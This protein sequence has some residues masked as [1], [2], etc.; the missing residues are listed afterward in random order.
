MPTKL[1]LK[2]GPLKELYFPPKNAMVLVDVPPLN[3]LMIDG[4]GDPNT[5]QVFQDAMGALYG[6]AYTLKF[7]SKDQGQDFTVMPLEGLWWSKDMTDFSM[8]RKDNWQW[9][10]LIAQPEHITETMVAAAAEQVRAKKNPP[11]LDNL[12]FEMYHEGLAAQLLYIGPYADEGPTITRLHAWIAEQGYTVQGAKPH[13]EIYM[14]APGRTQP[15][16][17]KTVIRQPVIR[18]E[19]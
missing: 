1:D 11:G 4:A 13:H 14:S 5:A 17:L 3:F 9:T 10:V 15:E 2:K 7:M 18:V 8:G 12:R 16:N 19:G 6:V